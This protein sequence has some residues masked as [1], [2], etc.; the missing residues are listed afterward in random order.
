MLA[1]R[2]TKA[3]D[4]DVDPYAPL[5]GDSPEVASWRE[6]MGTDACKASYKLRSS[7]AEF[8][9]AVFCNY[10]LHLFGVRGLAKV[11]SATLW[12]VLTHD[13]SCILSLDWLDQA[14]DL[15]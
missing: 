3:S 8:P 2:T 6:R 1:F 4:R 15:S 11:R 10:G 9:N 5:K 7:I 14:E 13:I 12:Q